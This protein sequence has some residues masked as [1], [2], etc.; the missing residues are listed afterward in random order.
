MV[1]ARVGIPALVAL[2]A[3][4]PDAVVRGP[5][6]RAQPAAKGAHA[7]VDGDPSTVD[8]GP[9]EPGDAQEPKE[10]G[11]GE[12]VNHSPF[13][14]VE[15]GPDLLLGAR[16]KLKRRP[17]APGRKGDLL[18]AIDTPY[19]LFGRA[20][21][22]VHV[23]AWRRD[24]RPAAHADVFV[25]RKG[26]GRTDAH[27]TL[28]FRWRGVAD[29][30]PDHEREDHDLFVIDGA[31][32]CGVVGF[33]PYS[34]TAGF[35]SDQLYVYTDRGVYRPG[36]TV[37]VRAIGWH[38]AADYAPIE[39]GEIE[40]LLR[41]GAGHSL[42]A[43][44]PTTDEFGTASAD[45]EVPLSTEEG[46]YSLEVAY[47]RARESTD[48]QIR[49]F[50]PPALRIE[51]TLPRMIGPERD[52]IAFTVSAHPAGGGTL[53]KG[54]ISVS[55]GAGR[56]GA[57]ELVR[58]V[59]G[60][61]PHAFSVGGKQ[62]AKLRQGRR[63]GDS[64]RFVVTVRDEH[65]REDALVRSVLLA[66][67]PWVGVLEPDRDEHAPGEA[68][69]VV[70]RISDLDDVA[71][72]ETD[73]TLKGL[74]GKPLVAR[75]NGHGVARFEFRMPAKPTT[76]HLFAPD[77]D[78]PIATTEL[79][80]GE[81]AP[82]QGALAEPI[83]R[84]RAST[85]IAV[86]FP[87][88]HE[89]IDRR[90]H[91]DVTD[92][93]GAL[94]AGAVL[95][96]KKDGEAWVARGEFSVPTWGSAMLTFFALGRAPGAKG[97]GGIGLL[98]AGR[99][100]AVLPDRVLE[101]ELHGLPERAAP[102][103]E[104]RVEARVRDAR[105][106][107]VRFAAS[108]ALVDSAVLA[109]NDPLEVG[110]VDRFYDPDLRT[111]AT[112]GA[113]ILTWPVVS[114]NWGDARHDIALPP[115]PF[116]EGGSVDSCTS[117]W[118]E[119][120]M[121]SLGEEIGG[122]GIGSGFG[123][124]GSIGSGAGS[125][126]IGVVRGEPVIT[127]R[128]RFSDTSLWLP[129][130][131]GDGKAK[132]R[133][134]LPDR[135]GEQELV[136]V[137]SDRDGGVGIARERI[138]VTQAVFVEADLPELAIAGEHIEIPVVVHNGTSIGDAFRVALSSGGEK[139]N[140]RVHVAGNATGSAR[141][142]LVTPRAGTASVTIE[143]KG[144]SI[145]DVAIEDVAV[146]PAGVAVPGVI[147][148]KP[149][150]DRRLEMIVDV[151]EHAGRVDAHLHVALPSIT[152]SMLPI[153]HLLEVVGDDPYALAG[154]LA[155][156]GVVLA[157]AKRHGL[158]TP[159]IDRLRADARAAVA[160]LGRVQ[161]SDGRF[162]YW[163]N[164]KASA[165]ITAIVLDALLSARR[166]D[167]PVPG[168]SIRAAASA[169]GKALE[170]GE[171]LDVAEVGWWEGDET[172]VREGITA[173]AWL[174]LARV[175]KDLRGRD[176]DTAL[177]ALTRRFR[178]TV[179]DDLADI[180]TTAHAVA[181]MLEQGEIDRKR[182]TEI[183][184]RLVARRDRGHWEPSWFSAFGGTIEATTAVLEAIHALDPKAFE[185][186][187]RDAVRWLLSTSPSWGEWHNE[188]GTAAAL[189]SLALFAD[190]KGALPKKLEV[191]V[192][193]VR[194]REVEVDARDAL[195]SVLALGRID[196]GAWTEGRHTVELRWDEG[197]A[198]VAGVVTRTWQRGRGVAARGSGAQ[199]RAD[200][201]PQVRL[202]DAATLDVHLGGRGLGGATLRIA[203]SGLVELDMV[204]LGARVGRGR[205]IADVVVGE[206]AI[207]LRLAPDVRARS[208]SL[209]FRAVR[210]GVGRWPAIALSVRP[211]GKNA[212]APL[213]VDPG[214]LALR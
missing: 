164:G 114:R 53:R 192:D 101:I 161:Q 135:I 147:M 183:V 46:E 173:E 71:L 174:V 198:P 127:I 108:A 126:T 190:G 31:A 64:L 187:T 83:V 86:R 212:S 163:R 213:V 138:A 75:T 128:K 12:K 199:L 121:A 157:L 8:L 197:A 129:D 19:Q 9:P 177:H 78:V 191:F 165:Y 134:R 80:I 189:R 1:R 42:A 20:A 146:A 142:E 104:L 122:F 29:E 109:L 110:P 25:G 73:V 203:R 140:A 18:V 167:L 214:P 201:D 92:T 113:D 130:L 96:A 107:P 202:G 63:D 32:R 55:V 136:V 102:G 16:A 112:T 87:R 144:E 208:L 4:R 194:T 35:A 89:P 154:D 115:F 79:A 76:I 120:D 34:R 26:V 169:L 106:R 7:R 145:R 39:G 175:P 13:H 178:A 94:V 211:R 179:D 131:R 117:A 139:R 100:L 22:Y 21:S 162:A 33:T 88:G 17:N 43:A 70:A 195:G 156:A 69:V 111:L 149:T 176:V 85:E 74:P 50:E 160:M 84:E 159:A 37:H 168:E 23:A 14:F 148:A 40:L 56:T 172:R 61:G 3:C 28:V 152:S 62:L 143:A 188:R 49:A 27:G 30:T 38:L 58:E 72:R 153:E 6:P 133:A 116:H 77:V 90:V 67:T 123:G 193:G 132:I 51:H 99:E 81:V 41:D 124:M 95:T 119:Q 48:L 44:H 181:A 171:L 91:M 118:D 15:R 2:F 200:A 103:A 209:P 24:G 82:M 182:A 59:A 185:V 52:A 180:R 184:A 60:S 155:S 150:G 137:A 47:A 206:D 141:L 11:D 196:V 105:G 151:P 68:V 97:K 210:R 36:E 170:R 45:L 125:G 186:E 65:G 158:A 54:R 66:K 93:S 204:R 5:E 10:D 57:L 166:A 205:A 207:E 98:V